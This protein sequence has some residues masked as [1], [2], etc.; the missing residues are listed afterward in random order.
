MNE[1]S[2]QNS[3]FIDLFSGCGGLSLGLL[4]SGFR[5]VFAIEKAADAFE[6]FKANLIDGPGGSRFSW[7]SWLE[8]KHTGIED[9]LS[10]HRH[11][12]PSLRGE[13]S[14]IAGGPP[15]QGFSFAGRRNKKDPRNR[16]FRK[17]VEFVAA[18]QPHLLLLENVPGMK[19]AH[20]TTE[21]RKK[22]PGRKPKSYYD[23]LIEALDAIG[24]VAEGRLID[25]SSFGV[26]QRRP[27]LVVIGMKKSMLKKKP[28]GISEIFDCIETCGS[29]QNRRLGLIGPVS[30]SDAISDLEVNRGQKIPCVDPASPK[31]FS[32]LDYVKP[33]TTYQKLMHGDTGRDEMDSMRLARHT[34]VVRER[35]EF[36][37]KECRRG[38]NLSEADRERY[39]LLK[40]RTLPMSPTMPAPTLTTLPDDVLHY[41]EPRILTV[42]EYARIQSFPDWYKFRGKYTTGGL[43]RKKDCPRYTQIG[44]AVPPL[45]AE[46][47]GSALIGV[48]KQ[49]VEDKT[50]RAQPKVL[51]RQTNGGRALKV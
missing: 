21:K 29:I 11:R 20:G 28:G 49:L 15:C 39:G 33:V 13:V 19:V 40:H 30:A 45:L 3:S 17:Y 24:Y 48:L 42:R 5:G 18:V 35:F 38:F 41:S 10:K 51:V 2:K 37:L 14:V 4:N 23:R 32:M 22:H 36:I 1:D 9:F 46:A 16:L 8:K 26:P 50:D 27:R 43:R 31:G 44:N 47:I 7:P 34:D 6:T 25:A 12:L